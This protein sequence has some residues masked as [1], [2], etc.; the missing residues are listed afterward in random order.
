[1]GCNECEHKS[2]VV[3][4]GRQA[5]FGL[6]GPLMDIAPRQGSSTL[7]W[8]PLRGQNGEHSALSGILHP[9]QSRSGMSTCA[10]VRQPNSH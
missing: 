3:L 9:P 2:V 1:M 4:T 5:A 10:A 8:T 6:L 7:T